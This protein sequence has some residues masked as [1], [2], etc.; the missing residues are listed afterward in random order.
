MMKK[1][2]L[3][4]ILIFLLVTL[5]ACGPQPDTTDPL[6][7]YNVDVDLPF[8]TN[9]SGP[10]ALSTP[11]TS[12]VSGWMGDVITLTE[13]EYTELSLG[14]IGTRVKNLQKRLIEL[15]YMNG[16]ASGTF[17]QA[18]V[19]AVKLFEE[20]YGR[21]Q[22]GRAT[23]VM[24]YY[25]FSETVRKYTKTNATATPAAQTATYRTLQRGDTGSDVQQLQQ[26]LYDL[27]YL[28]Q[29][30]G[31][32]YDAATENA[33]KDFESGYG[34]S[35]TGIATVQLQQYLYA[36]NAKSAWEVKTYTPTPT[37]APTARFST[38]KS[39]SK[40]DA[41]TELQNRL[42][43]LGYMRS[44]A[45]GIYGDKTVEAVKLF[46]KTYGKAETGIATA[47]LQEF[48]FSYDVDP[49]GSVIVTATPRATASTNYTTLS[50]GSS[51]SAVTQL[52]T[53]LWELG[54]LEGE[55]DGVFGGGTERAVKLFESYHGATQTG[56]AT[57]AM[58]EFLFSSSAQ[59]Y[60]KE[61]LDDDTG[62]A[63]EPEE[64]YQTLSKG[65]KNDEVKRLQER[66][67]EL[68]YLTGVADGYFGDGTAAAVK[69]FEKEYGRTQTG[70]ATEELQK[71]LFSG[72][73]KRNS[74]SDIA[75]SYSSLSSGASGQAV[76]NLQ[77]QLYM[78][79]YYDG[80]ITGSYDKATMN[81]VKLYQKVKG[82][83]Q[84]GTASSSL[85]K[86]IFADTTYNPAAPDDPGSSGSAI[87][88]NKPAYVS[89]SS[90]KVYND[91][92]YPTATVSVAGGTQ[93]TVLRVK[94]EWAEVRSQSGSV[95]YCKL[96]DLTYG[97]APSG[98]NTDTVVTVN[99]KAE[100]T[101]KVTVYE[102]A[103]ESAKVLGSLSKGTTVTWLRTRGNWAE[104]Q[105]SSGAK[106]YCKAN[107]LKTV[108]GTASE[109]T[110]SSYGMTGSAYRGL[111]PNDTGDDVK[112]M[113]TRLTQLNYFYGDIGGNY[114]TKTTDAVKRFQKDI[115]L[116]PDGIATPGLL[117]ILYSD[118]APKPGQYK[119]TGTNSY[120]DLAYGSKGD[121]VR[122]LQGQLNVL[123]YLMSGFT[124]GTYDNATAAAVMA[125]QE[126][127]GLTQQD[128]QATRE[129]QALLNTNIAKKI[130]FQ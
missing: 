41:V 3:P 50:R 74:K 53:R 22:T 75:V 52:Q 43:E 95:G 23:Q 120:G 39:G 37:P 126:R 125:V 16:T 33:V 91:P 24:Q 109:N 69:G 5:C 65:D 105:N 114:L 84:T 96:S 115:G 45:D 67:I 49:Y 56:V 113:Q 110:Q 77:Q 54:Y 27:G 102:S 72:S 2:L 48:L 121:A 44:K 122:K 68:G 29:V 40:G 64:S 36:S 103:S 107:A 7:G 108:D 32:Y 119:D 42:R 117:D 70:I 112:K 28:S 26:R 57:P 62:W 97:S 11:K 21:Q 118:Y 31:S 106:G 25:L 66:L 111:K 13:D 79:G 18:T 78:L 80:E 124:S 38:L 99:K 81:A 61:E 129:L 17:D 98:G 8:A 35:R 93:V 1:V 89:A 101:A 71:Y 14:S 116:K 92:D 87:E 51:G 86:Q 63:W 46:E 6:S 123:G 104:I 82:L 128:G 34:K 30:S 100:V 73:A 59:Y 83:T 55:I 85:Q 60:V 4:L 58:Q 12:K 9:S 20:A 15:G 76:S 127:L 90:A 47:S 94:G 130:A 88:V 19:L 10:N